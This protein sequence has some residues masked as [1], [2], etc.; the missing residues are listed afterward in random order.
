M[1]IYIASDHV[2][3]ELKE[4]LKTYLSG[5]G[6]SYEV[7]D[8]GAFNYDANDDYPDFVKPLAQAVAEDKESRGIIVAG[9]GEAMCANRTLGVRAAV[10]Y[11]EAVAKEAIDIKGQQ[12]IDPYEIIKLT[13]I[14]ND[15]NILS[16]SIRFL[17][18]DQIKF[19]IELFLR[20]E[21][22]GEERHI[23]RINKLG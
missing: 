2:G 1:K 9:Q 11:G 13:R 15:A 7:I 5:L 6:L 22:K 3:Y 21:F 8:K 23:R 19:A 12:S 14:H 20:T 16:L 18:E 10:F 17:S 4:K